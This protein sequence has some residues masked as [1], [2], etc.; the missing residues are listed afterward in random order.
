LRAPDLAGEGETLAA[1][2]AR[3]GLD[4]EVWALMRLF[5]RL[6]G[7][8]NDPDKQSARAALAQL[9]Q[10]TNGGVA[11]VDG[12]W[13]TLV[14]GLRDV[15][16]GSGVLVRTGAQVHALARADRGWR[17]ELDAETIVARAVILAT[18]PNVAS[19]LTGARFNVEPVSAA[20]LDVGL[21]RLPRPDRKLVLGL[22]RP[23]YFSVHSACARLAPE[24]ASLV[25]LLMYHGPDAPPRESDLAELE[26][27]LELA[28]PGW[29]EHVLVR[30]FL[31]R[32]IVTHALV[33]PAGRPPE[34]V[35][36]GMF[37]AGDWVGQEG[38]L[39]DAAAASAKRAAH[40]CLELFCAR[41]M[42]APNG[43]FA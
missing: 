13:A 19:T 34:E 27:L 26:A 6:T 25:Q 7:Y 30:R 5:F 3:K 31:P 33:T 2:R 29:R 16:S 22:E 23:L 12:G 1:W 36:P 39:A 4:D 20:C 38:M 32:M 14:R 17:V 8:A 18:P 24:G 21:A 40:A 11:Y 10:A 15:A 43:A 37:V 9:H 41:T 42:G 28:Q 35:L